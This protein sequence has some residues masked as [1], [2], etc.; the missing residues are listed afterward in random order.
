MTTSAELLERAIAAMDAGQEAQAQGFLAQALQLDPRNERAWLL[1]A[2]AQADV[3]RKRYCIERALALNPHHDLAL[4]MM[5]KLSRPT[6]TEFDWTGHES[7]PPAPTPEEAPEAAPVPEDEP[8]APAAPPTPAPPPSLQATSPQQLRLDLER[9][10]SLI[11][12]GERDQGFELLEQIVTADPRN[13]QA[14]LWLAAISGDPELKRQRLERALAINPKSKL[15]RKMLAELDATATVRERGAESLH[16][17][18]MD[19]FEVWLSALTRPSE[20]TYLEFLADPEASGTR[21]FLWVASASALSFALLWI[22]IAIFGTAMIPPE[23]LPQTQRASPL[24]VLGV[25]LVCGVPLVA[26]FAALGLAIFAGIVHLTAWISGGRGSYGG[27]LYAIAA[28]YAPLQIVS[29]LIGFIPWVNVCV[30]SLLG[31]YAL[32]LNMLAAKAAH[33]LGWGGA[34][35]AGLMP[36]LLAVVLAACGAFF[37]LSSL[38]SSPELQDLLRTLATPQP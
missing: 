38:S 25:V 15:G 29:T 3:E 37:I 11:E 27:T 17:R 31:L 6:S 2:E 5:A 21:A 19:W 12:R 1:M 9:A 16:A 13:E 8:S 24:I 18:H 26:L 33:R 35:L 34:A 10:V 23:A 22:L 30:G 20:Q 32:Y 28:Y 14:W 36:T 4:Q 7:T